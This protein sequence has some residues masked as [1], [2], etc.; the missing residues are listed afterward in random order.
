MQQQRREQGD[1]ADNQQA[2]EKYPAHREITH[3]FGSPQ[4]GV[5]R[6]TGK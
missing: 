6:N 4:A 1:K 3:G 2:G 5:R